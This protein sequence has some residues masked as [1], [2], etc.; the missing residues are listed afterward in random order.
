M[1][2]TNT[3]PNR[4]SSMTKA[5]LG[6][7]QTV[8]ARTYSVPANLDQGSAETL[9][10]A[11]VAKARL[12]NPGLHPEVARVLAKWLLA[13]SVVNARTEEEAAGRKAQP[14][15]ADGTPVG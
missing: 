15:N 14:Q 12:P 4:T 3:H 11:L 8:L 5:I 10:C 6:M 13:R 9:A 7:A 2:V 1:V